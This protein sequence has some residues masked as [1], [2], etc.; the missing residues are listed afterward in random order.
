MAATTTPATTDPA[1]PGG[2]TDDLVPGSLITR[3]GQVQWAGLLMGPGTPYQIDSAGLTG[4]EDIPDFDT[5]D[6]DRPTAHGAWP[7]SRYAKPRKVSG[8]MWVLPAS[9]GDATLTTVRALRKAL[10]LADEERWLTVRLHGE[11]LTVRA[12]VSQRVLPVDRVYALQGVAHGSVQWQAD[13]PRRY[14]ANEQTLDSS[15]PEPETG[16]TFPLAFPLD[17][18]QA[19]STG[20]VSGENTGSAPT[21][22]VLTFTGPCTNPTVTERVSGK[23]LRYVITLTAG[24][25]LQVDTMAGTV[26]LNGTA[27]RRHTAAADSDPE[28]LFAFG[29]GRFELSFRPDTS[30][31][32]A[33][34]SVSWRSAE[35]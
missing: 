15:P 22:P 5:S 31:A 26:M 1:D 4:W 3:D 25:Q 28:E 13:D 27:S 29:P 16:L 10:S 19:T 32:D 35:W 24:D 17:F 9:P 18:G 2:L 33:R 23:R 34:L 8:Q 21:Q 6:A 7:G 11:L 14:G 20:D 12:R 30:T